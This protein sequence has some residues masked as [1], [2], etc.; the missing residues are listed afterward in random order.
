ML[1]QAAV[2]ALLAL[3]VV[4]ASTTP[5]D[6]MEVLNIVKDYLFPVCTTHGVSQIDNVSHTKSCECDSGYEGDFCEIYVGDLHCNTT[7]DIPLFIA[8]VEGV[9]TVRGNVYIT[10]LCVVPESIAAANQLNTIDGSVFFYEPTD[11]RQFWVTWPENAWETVTGCVIIAYIPQ[12]N[13]IGYPVFPKLSS[14]GSCSLS[15]VQAV[16][17]AGYTRMLVNRSITPRVSMMLSTFGTGYEDCHYG[18]NDVTFF[19]KLRTMPGALVFDNMPLHY[20]NDMILEHVG[21]LYV[22]S[23]Y[24]LRRIGIP[25][26]ATIG[27]HGLLLEDSSLDNLDDFAGVRTVTLGFVDIKHMYELKNVLSFNPTIIERT[28]TP[29]T[30]ISI[31]L[32]CQ[33]GYHHGFPES[34]CTCSSPE[35]SGIL[36]DTIT[37]TFLCMDPVQAEQLNQTLAN[38]RHVVGDIHLT[39]SCLESSL[40]FLPYL[41]TVE[42]SIYINSFGLPIIEPFFGALESASVITI[43]S[44]PNSPLHWFPRLE[45]VGSLGILNVDEFVNFTGFPELTTITDGLEVVNCAGATSFAG[46]EN[47]AELGTLSVIASPQLTDYSAFNGPEKVALLSQNNAPALSIDA[48]TDC[49][50]LLLHLMDTVVIA[51][52]AAINVPWTT[53]SGFGLVHPG[54]LGCTCNPGYT[55]FMCHGYN[56]D[57]IFCNTSSAHIVESMLAG[58]THIYSSLVIQE[59][60]GYDTNLGLLDTVDYV[61]DLYF[62]TQSMYYGKIPPHIGNVTIFDTMFWTLE[63]FE[64]SLHI[65]SLVVQGN[66]VMYSL[67]GINNLET[68]GQI[69]ISDNMALTNVDALSQLVSVTYSLVIYNNDVDV[70][71]IAFDYN[72]IPT[73]YTYVAG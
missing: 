4:P 63:G 26:L 54:D 43:E 14:V 64:Q 29:S 11:W 37:G 28:G 51:D 9:T 69:V 42:G 57:T 30:S 27:E 38:V 32:A 66:S 49:E 16:L 53:C 46:L 59:L 41:R 68:A 17:P 12:A 48:C 50:A 21:G 60:C 6:A 52:G 56:G 24:H 23:C 35:Y 70:N 7:N 22:I 58:V 67:E 1:R 20:G 19:G 71:S 62:N 72:S 45:T 2:L 15:E 47:V 33:N 40:L 8:A 61:A 36:C 31:Q 39:D 10:A 34:Q 44:V 65:D 18:C 3:M 55:D 25:H 73:A 5:V 13:I